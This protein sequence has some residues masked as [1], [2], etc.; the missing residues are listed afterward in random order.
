[1]TSQIPDTFLQRTPVG[2]RKA[3]LSCRIPSVALTL[4][5]TI[6]ISSCTGFSQPT[7]ET[8]ASQTPTQ[9]IFHIDRSAFSYGIFETEA[10]SLTLDV[11]NTTLDF[12][13]ISVEDESGVAIYKVKPG[14][15]VIVHSMSPVVKHVIITSGGQSKVHN[16]IIGMFIDKITFNEPA[17]QIHPSNKRIVIYGDSIA[18]GGNVPNPSTEAWPILLR[19]YHS[20]VVNAYG[21]RSL[22]DDSSTPEK[23]SKFAAEISSWI[24][25]Y[26]WLAVGTNDY[27]FQAWSA[28][29]F[30]EAY[31]ATLDAIHLSNPQAV[32]FAQSPI[33]RAREDPN[34]FGDT[35]E[36]YRQQIAAACLA[37]S[38]WCVFVDGTSSAFPQP[39]ELHKDGV[40]LTTQSSIKYAEAVLDIIGE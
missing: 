17:V 2:N 32:L 9:T 19:K 14:E 31:A 39:N 8:S 18:G 11:S 7:K 27:R 6:F 20:V 30:G 35:P 40:H 34:S 13:D 25:D 21:Y 16:E 33:R 37:R 36:K 23:R 22:Y 29:D 24:P 28:Q 10:N 26:I 15:A 3:I 4:L 1:M 38:T 5:L 12:A